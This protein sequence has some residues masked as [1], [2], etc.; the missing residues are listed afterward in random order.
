MVSGKEILIVNMIVAH[1]FTLTKTSQ[2]KHHDSM[3]VL[4]KGDSASREEQ[5]KLSA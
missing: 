1:T 3:S 4:Q 2:D 5:E